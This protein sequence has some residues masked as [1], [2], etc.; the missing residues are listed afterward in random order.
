MGQNW[1]LS[2]LIAVLLRFTPDHKTKLY[3][4]LTKTR[5]MLY[6]VALS[7]RGPSLFSMKVLGLR[8]LPLALWDFVPSI[9][10]LNM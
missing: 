5:Q 7:V 9:G 6:I 3:F 10:S 8:L 1:H 2:L 4:M